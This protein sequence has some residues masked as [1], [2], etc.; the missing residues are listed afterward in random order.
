MR[1]HLEGR[2]SDLTRELLIFAGTTE[3]RKL[4]DFVRRNQLSAE[5]V[6]AT[7]YGREMLEESERIRVSCGRLDE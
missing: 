5:V 6:V 1:W 4:V 3:G 2:E 7:D